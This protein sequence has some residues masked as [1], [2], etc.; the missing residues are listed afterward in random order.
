MD[1]IKSIITACF[2][3]LLYST[4]SGQD[5]RVT[6]PRLKKPEVAKRNT[7]LI[8]GYDLERT[9]QRLI[10]GRPMLGYLNVG[11]QHRRQLRNNWALQYDLWINSTATPYIQNVKLS[12]E[13]LDG[14][15]FLI[16]DT[17]ALMQLRGASFGISVAR[18]LPYGIHLIGGAQFAYFDEGFFEYSYSKRSTVRLQTLSTRGGPSE[19]APTEDWIRRFHPMLRFGVEKDFFKYAF[20]GINFQ[21]SLIDLTKNDSGSPNLLFNYHA[22]LGGRFFW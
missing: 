7:S 14:R 8:I 18:K 9:E 19:F 3:T 2:I 11:I 1:Q 5:V 6:F 13:D 20:I 16:E 21:Q 15:R 12:K 4:A 17:T 10:E 22:Y